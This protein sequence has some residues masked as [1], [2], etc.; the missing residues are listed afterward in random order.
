MVE[1]IDKIGQ[2]VHVTM[3]EF[4]DEIEFIFHD[5]KAP[6]NEVQR[7]NVAKEHFRFC[8]IAKDLFIDG[9]ENKFAAVLFANGCSEIPS[10]TVVFTRN[11]CSDPWKK[12]Y[13]HKEECEEGFSEVVRNCF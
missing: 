6:F 9:D 1:R 11:S 7:I 2:I 5:G 10:K 13:E 3:N 12:P 8:L 4:N